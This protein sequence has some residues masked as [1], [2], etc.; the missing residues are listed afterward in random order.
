MENSFTKEIKF[1][2]ALE[3]L[4]PLEKLHKQRIQQII[5]IWKEILLSQGC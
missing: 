5:I 3:P 1:L 2:F 4:K